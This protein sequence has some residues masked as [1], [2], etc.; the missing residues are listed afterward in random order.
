NLGNISQ[1]GFQGSYYANVEEKSKFLGMT[2]DTSGSKRQSSLDPEI[3]RQ[4]TSILT[5]VGDAVKYGAL[6][7]GESI[8]DVNTRLSNY[9]V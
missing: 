8:A 3:E 5:G 2:Y 9:V 7:L 1:G 4:I 6:A